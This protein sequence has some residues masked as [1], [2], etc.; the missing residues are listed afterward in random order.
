MGSISGTDTF[1]KEFKRYFKRGSRGIDRNPTKKT[2]TYVHVVRDE[3]AASWVTE[4]ELYYRNVTNNKWVFA[5]TF[6]CNYNGYD[7]KLVDL[8]P[9]YNAADGLYTQYLRI[10]PLHYHIRPTLL[11]SIYQYHNET[12]T[13]GATTTASLSPTDDIPTVRYE[14]NENT[15]EAYGK[16]RDGFKRRVLRHDRWRWNK[17]ESKKKRRSLQQLVEEDRYG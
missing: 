11:V 17:N 2:A 7:I 12:S 15:C 10:K 8:Y 6:L 16:C 14:V 9:F 13:S 4:F 3:S 5:S 1:P